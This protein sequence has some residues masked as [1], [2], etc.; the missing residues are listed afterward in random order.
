VSLNFSSSNRAAQLPP[1]LAALDAAR[2]SVGWRAWSGLGAAASVIT[3]AIIWGIVGDLPT[4]V[5][6]RCILML[7]DGVA[8]VTADAPGRLTE[9]LVQPGTMVAA[10]QRVAVVAT[11]ELSERVE[12]ARTRVADLDAALAAATSQ[13]RRSTSFSEASLAEQLALL[14]S[15]REATLRR[16]SIAEQQAATNDL[17]RRDGLIT[18]RSRLGA[19]LDLEDARNALLDVDRR[20]A[21]AGKRRTDFMHRTTRDVSTLAL[22]ANDARRELQGLLAQS[23]QFTQVKSPVAG[24]V[25]E[26]KAARGTLVKR[27]TPVIAVE[28]AS[29]I[30]GT[31]PAGIAAPQVAGS[32]GL[33]VLMFVSAAN[34]KKIERAAQAEIIP[35]VTRREEHG[36]LRGQV[37]DISE[38]PSTPQGLLARIANPDLMHELARTAAPFQ[39]RIRLDRADPPQ[40]GAV[41]PY[42]WSAGAGSQVAISSGTLC[43]GEILVRH[44]RPI[45]LV[46]PIFRSTLR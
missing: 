12:N 44:E 5:A 19:G 28:R 13:T 1:A 39:V 35:D 37:H 36:V 15:Q 21:E 26:I 3:G 23:N 32:G 20:I 7:P 22:Q 38:Y 8:D 33:E 46:I 18:E 16:I 40:P 24:R 11:P 27:D 43:Q 4:R 25:V 14:H 2:S 31:P 42:D 30:S 41:N 34:G 6:G 29:L 9:L 17:L 10:G 45:G